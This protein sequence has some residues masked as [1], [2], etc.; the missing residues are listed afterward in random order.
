MEARTGE[1][2]SPDDPGPWEFAV[3]LYDIPAVRESCLSLQ[4]LG[5]ADVNVL[6][7]L[8]Y[9][10]SR[11]IEIDAPRVRRLLDRTDD[12]RRRVVEPLR[13]ARRAVKDLR[14]GDESLY[15]RLKAVE[16]CAEHVSQQLL[17]SEL[18]ALA[19]SAERSDPLIAARVNL[20]AYATQVPMP[21]EHLTT[22]LTAFAARRQSR[23]P[24]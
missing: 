1:S 12:W 23:S 17:G 19:A 11:G 9:A 21:E 10:A 2:S 8:L 14:P 7:A 13:S 6:L 22:L 4:D 18:D 5:G 3:D 20:A 24:K 15:G 16:L